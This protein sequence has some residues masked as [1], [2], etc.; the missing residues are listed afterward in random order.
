MSVTATRP[1]SVHGDAFLDTQLTLRAT[2]PALLG[3]GHDKRYTTA[4]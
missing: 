2:N 4:R 3:E 1:F